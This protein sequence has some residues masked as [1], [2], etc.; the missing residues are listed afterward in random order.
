MKNWTPKQIRELRTK[1]KLSQRAFS[2]LAGVTENYVFYLEKGVR[3]PGKSL[4]L[5]FDCI[6]E[7]YL[8]KKGGE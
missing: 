6:V 1:L 8:N 4:K 3:N 5:L 7:K 2:E